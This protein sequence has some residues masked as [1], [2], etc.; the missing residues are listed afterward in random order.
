[1]YAALEMRREGLDVVKKVTK[2]GM[3]SYFGE[4][5]PSAKAYQTE[6]GREEF[7]HEVAKFFIGSRFCQPWI[8][9]Y[10]QKEGQTHYPCL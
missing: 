4:Y 8:L 3:R 1:M 9:L 2:E 7:F 6:G 5:S 10:A